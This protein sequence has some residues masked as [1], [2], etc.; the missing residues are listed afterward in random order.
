MSNKI[1]NQ[2]EFESQVRDVLRFYPFQLQQDA[3]G[4]VSVSFNANGIAG[5]IVD[6]ARE[7]YFSQGQE[8]SFAGDDMFF[9]D[10]V[11]KKI[12]NIN[13]SQFDSFGPLFIQ[14]H[15]LKVNTW[16]D[17]FARY[18]NAGF[19]NIE[20]YKMTAYKSFYELRGG[21]R[22]HEQT[23]DHYVLT[24]F[25]RVEPWTVEKSYFASFPE[26]EA[27]EFVPQCGPHEE[28]LKEYLSDYKPLKAISRVALLTYDEAAYKLTRRTS[29]GS[30]I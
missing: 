28:L 29:Q 15:L 17:A 4:L 11:E 19:S 16:A 3:D 27:L 18:I 30:I 1:P 7:M 21:Y 24:N 9:Y 8:R 22:D 23:T 6:I 26:E 14:K 5:K 25:K 20:A 13:R 12:V 2:K 10:H